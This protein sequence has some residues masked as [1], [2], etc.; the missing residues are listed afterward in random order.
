MKRGVALA[1]VLASA[2]LGAEGM[3]PLCAD[4]CAALRF[5]EFVT[6][7]MSATDETEWWGIGAT[8]HRV[9]SLAEANGSRM[10]DL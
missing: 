7:P 1:V 8:A 4:E 2:A 6:G 3:K 9:I 10:R 5:L